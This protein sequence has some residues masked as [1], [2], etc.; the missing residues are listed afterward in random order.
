M[1][2]N[3]CLQ[4]GEASLHWK[5]VLNN[6]EVNH[7]WNGQHQNPRWLPWITRIYRAAQISRNLGFVERTQQRE[8]VSE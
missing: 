5:F 7:G 2:Y 4:K 8:K 3:L 6:A 1:K